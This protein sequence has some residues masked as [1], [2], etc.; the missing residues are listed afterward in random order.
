LAV[1]DVS[2]TNKLQ[3]NGFLCLE[4]LTCT[5]STSE[6]K[7]VTVQIDRNEWI[8]AECWQ[9]SNKVWRIR[10]V[11]GCNVKE[12]EMEGEDGLCFGYN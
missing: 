12:R 1:I 9:G 7:L 6:A 5:I 8:G 2:V 11:I 3:F 4:F 10:F